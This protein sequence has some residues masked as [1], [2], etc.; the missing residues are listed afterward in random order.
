M[1]SLEKA[2]AEIEAK[3]HGIMAL[4]LSIQDFVRTVQGRSMIE[5]QEPFCIQGA[6][7]QG[8]EK[9]A[10][11]VEEKQLTDAE[12]LRVHDCDGTRK[13]VEAA[14]KM[15]LEQRSVL[16]DIE[17][18]E[19]RQK[20]RK[21]LLDNV[22]LEVAQRQLAELRKNDKKGKPADADDE[23][24]FSLPEGDGQMLACDECEETFSSPAQLKGHKKIAHKKRKQA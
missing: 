16:K 21:E 3:T 23:D 12:M 4:G 19:R 14:R 1:D 5:S 22:Q 18:G 6:I 11:M 24:P 20:K 9:K 13:R 10:V 8:Y 17:L 2:R 7:Y 15:R